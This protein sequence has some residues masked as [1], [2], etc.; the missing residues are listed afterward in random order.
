MWSD[1]MQANLPASQNH[2]LSVQQTE[3]IP[4]NGQDVSIS[5]IAIA[6]LNAA[7]TDLPDDKVLS[8]TLKPNVTYE[9]KIELSNK[10]Q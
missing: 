7:K 2:E 10:P 8:V 9:M 3:N 1:T 5:Q 4:L 6:L